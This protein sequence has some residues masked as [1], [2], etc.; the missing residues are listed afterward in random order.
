[1]TTTLQITNTSK[2]FEMLGDNAGLYG[3]NGGDPDGNMWLPSQAF[4]S[5]DVVKAGY[6]KHVNARYMTD[7]EIAKFCSLHV[8]YDAAVSD[9][10]FSDFKNAVDNVLGDKGYGYAHYGA[11]GAMDS[12]W[13]VS[14]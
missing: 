13:V 1:M 5:D 12:Q 10:D 2:A 11:Y 3:D 6:G 7:E 4:T 9:R 8:D 14:K